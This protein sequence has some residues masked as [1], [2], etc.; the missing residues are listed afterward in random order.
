L[1][2]VW[3]SGI[4]ALVGVVLGLGFLFGGQTK[5]D[6]RGGALT[7]LGVVFLA[8]LVF[9][10]GGFKSVPVK[11]VGVV[12]AFGHVGSTYKPGLH[13]T[14]PWNT[15]NILDE[16]VQTTTFSGK[17]CLDIRIGGQQTACLDVTIKWQVRDSAAA[18]LFQNYD[19]SGNIQGVIKN[20]LVVRELEQVVNQVM[21]DYNPIQDVAA[22]S[23]S[24]NS[25]F[26]TF[27][28]K[29]LTQ[30][31]SD[32]GSQIDVLSI[33]MPFAQYDSSTQS[34]L[35]AIQQQYAETA[36]ADEQVITNQAQA[37]ANAAIA[38]SVNN[39]PAVLEQ[40][41]LQTV[42]TAIK[43]GYQLPAGFNCLG[44]SSELALSTGK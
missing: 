15:V 43:S 28:P 26:S 39:S 41:C 12:T 13:H 29:V 22:N 44:G 1:L 32:I 42:Q 2:W 23:T 5:E 21:G 10:I 20:S 36:I 14:W 18:D 6:Q 16:T 37:K 33:I 9:F 19:T 8:F 3:I 35:N 27:G 40:E 4:V 30:M 38:Q 31:R 7:G 17:N 34:R 24:G 25:Q 11:S